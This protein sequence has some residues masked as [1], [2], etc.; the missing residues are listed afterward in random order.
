MPAPDA[1]RAWLN[2]AIAEFFSKH[3]NAERT[4]QIKAAVSAHAATAPVASH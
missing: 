2:D 4:S 3:Q 1:C